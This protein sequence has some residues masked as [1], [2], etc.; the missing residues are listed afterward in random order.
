MHFNFKRYISSWFPF[1]PF[2]WAR[3]VYILSRV[4][5]VQKCQITLLIDI[6]LHFYF[7]VAQKRLFSQ[8]IL[9]RGLLVKTFKWLHWLGKRALMEPN[10][11]Q[12]VLIKKTKPTGPF[13]GIESHWCGENFTFSSCKTFNKLLNYANLI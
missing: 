4:W 2:L 12:I 7:G 6:V 9:E 8:T 10:C 13:W 1:S 3:K 5:S 11:C